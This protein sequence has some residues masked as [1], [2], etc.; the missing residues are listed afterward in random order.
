[1]KILGN[2]LKNIYETKLKSQFP[3]NPCIVELYIP[4]PEGD[5]I[6]YQL[7]FWQVTHE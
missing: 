2:I 5:F 3:D 1:L 4:E 7:S 6:D